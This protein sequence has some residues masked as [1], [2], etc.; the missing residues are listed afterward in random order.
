MVL[1]GRRVE[2]GAHAEPDHSHPAPLAWSQ[3]PWRHP[4]GEVGDEGRLRQLH[5]KGH[6]L[7]GVCA[8]DSPGGD[9]IVSKTGGHLAADL[10]AVDLDAIADLQERTVLDQPLGKQPLHLAALLLGAP[11]RVQ[12]LCLVS[13]PFSFLG[14][15][16]QLA[17]LVLE[18]SGLSERLLPHQRPGG[19]G[20][21][22][23][24]REKG[25]RGALLCLLNSG[26]VS[27]QLAVARGSLLKIQS[28]CPFP[29]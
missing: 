14:L 17:T 19:V 6:L 25:E 11:C 10:G 28:D 22:M 18:G 5:V 8:V 27:G 13:G 7:G 16:I 12:G 24:G 1:Q 3:Q 15:P 26:C 21:K 9:D 2:L 29:T 4:Q 23:R 20:A